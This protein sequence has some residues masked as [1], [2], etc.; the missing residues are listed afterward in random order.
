[1]EDSGSEEPEETLTDHDGLDEE[2][3]IPAARTNAPR[4]KKFHRIASERLWGKRIDQYLILSGLG[5]SRSRAARLI[6]DGLVLVDPEEGYLSCGARGP[7]RMASPE[8]IYEVI[9]KTL[10]STAGS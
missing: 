8:T 6:E 7:G 9:Q 3:P 2:R 5:V 1:M 10:Q 4:I